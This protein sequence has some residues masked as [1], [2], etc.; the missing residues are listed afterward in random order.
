VFRALKEEIPG[1]VAMSIRDRDHD[2]VNT[3]DASLRDKS[4]GVVPDFH[5]RKWRRRHI[6][7]YLLWPPAIAAA[8][9]TLEE[10]IRQQLTDRFALAIPDSFA[11]ASVPQG[12]LDVPAKEVFK[13]GSVAILDQ[14][15]ASADAVAAEMPTEAVCADIKTIVDE[16]ITR[17]R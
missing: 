1:L 8:S 11:D 10:D 9:Q 6:E 7:S 17:A 13:Q 15:D 5:A 12:L 16:L 3:V 14:F 4:T 2:P